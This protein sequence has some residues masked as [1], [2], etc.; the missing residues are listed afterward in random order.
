[1]ND[2]AREGDATMM[3]MMAMVDVQK[4]PITG[5]V[6]ALVVA[7]VAGWTIDVVAVTTVSEEAEPQMMDHGAE[8]RLSV[9]EVVVS[10][11][12]A[13]TTIDAVAMMIDAVAMMT[14]SAAMIAGAVALMTGAVEVGTVIRRPLPLNA[15]GFNSRAARRPRR[16]RL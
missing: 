1:M 6:E 13:V 5:G 15:P 7:Q 2:A 12:D 4:E 9:Q 3:T 8:V 11:T 16:C 14:D 10:M